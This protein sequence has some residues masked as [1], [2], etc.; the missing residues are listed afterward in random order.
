MRGLSFQGLRGL[1]DN[2]GLAAVKAGTVGGAAATGT[3]ATLGLAPI[4][5]TA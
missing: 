5:C 4:A 3:A 1:E 2:A